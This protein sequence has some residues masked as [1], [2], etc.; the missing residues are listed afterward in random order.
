MAQGKRDELILRLPSHVR[1]ELDRVKRESGLSRN[2]IITMILREF[3]EGSPKGKTT[4][5]GD[6]EAA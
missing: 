6:K 1:K 3:F 2:F 5:I 4:T